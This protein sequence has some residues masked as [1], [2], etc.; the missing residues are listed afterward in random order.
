MK[1]EG[2]VLDRGGVRK[3]AVAMDLR[4]VGLRVA[5]VG[6]LIFLL[7]A[8]EVR[9][10]RVI[11]HTCTDL[12]QIPQWAVA[13]AAADLHVAYNHTSHGSQ[14]ISG[15]NA[16]ESFPPF[17]DTYAWSD[18]GAAG[19]DLDDRGIPC[20][21]PDLSQGDSIDGFGV[22]PWVTCTRD[23]L[24]SPANAHINVVL[25]SW[26]SINGHDAQRYVDNMEILI[27]EYPEVQF[28]FMTG[29]AEGDGEVMTPDSVHYNNQLIRQHCATHD[30]TLFDFADIEAYDPAGTYFWDLAL[31][32][33]LDYTGG[34]WAVEWLVDHPGS[35]LEQL[36]T[37]VGVS[38]SS[39][40]SSCAHSA[41]PS[42]ATLNCVLKG[43]AAWWMFAELAGWQGG[44]IFS[45]G[46]EAGD[47]RLWSS[48][49]M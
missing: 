30:R 47:S 15:M 1:A 2:L 3:G 28:V 34:N 32:D 14:L 4:T 25:W 46:F 27:A 23:F 33:N 40:L 37:G 44:S 38:G 7:G 17:G 11:D 41:A 20:G 43:R 31:R 22:T 45:D 39:G 42:D 24:D 18:D 6:S 21:T 26:C 19:L 35:E 12:D 48:S 29:H 49:S 9:G 13:R 5:L 8:L 16:L 36:T 10:Q